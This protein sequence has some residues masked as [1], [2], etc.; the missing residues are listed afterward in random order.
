[1]SR[2]H[3]VVV[4]FIF[5]GIGIIISAGFGNVLI[6]LAARDILRTFEEQMLEQMRKTRS[7]GRLVLRADMIGNI[8]ADDR[9]FMILIQDHMQDIVQIV[10]GKGDR[11]GL[12]HSWYSAR[13]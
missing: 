7:F 13:K 1:M 8:E 6:E 9:R 2:E 12:I 3:F 4:G 10:F 5:G 11:A